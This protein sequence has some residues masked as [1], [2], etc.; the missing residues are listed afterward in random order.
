MFIVPGEVL[1]TS[2]S[3]FENKKPQGFNPRVPKVLV[4][5]A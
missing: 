4:V 3:H 2:S 5:A 1:V